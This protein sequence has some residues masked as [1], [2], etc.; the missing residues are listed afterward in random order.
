MRPELTITETKAIQS[1]ATATFAVPTIIHQK[2]TLESEPGIS[3]ACLKILPELPMDNAEQGQIILFDPEKSSY[4]LYNPSV[5]ELQNISDDR[6][7]DLIVSPNRMLYAYR[8]EQSNKLMVFSSGGELQRSINWENNWETLGKWQ[9]NEHILLIKSSAASTEEYPRHLIV[10][11]P[12]SG[13]TQDLQP[14]YP[15]IENASYQLSWEGSGTTVYDPMF[16][17]VVYPGVIEG[18]GMGYI[19]FDLKNKT[20]LA[21]IQS[22]NFTKAPKWL[23]DG[24]QFIV[25]AKGGEFFLVSRDGEITQISHMSPDYDPTKNNFNYEASFYSWSPDGK[26]LALW[27]FSYKTN[28]T[29]LAVLDI[30][31]GTVTDF[32]LSHGPNPLN[33]PY[34]PIPIWSPD[35]TAIVVEANFQSENGENDVMLVDLIKK[36]AT[37]I[38]QNLTPVGWLDVP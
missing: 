17:R 25:N 18:K 11:N 4:V 24:S 10:L 27:L 6:V 8:D 5:K 9:N 37:R 22:P 26:Y 14:I 2:D 19:L 16:T 35:S 29:T 30:H 7:F 38:S 32:C 3:Q 33:M 13:E 15:S 12:F 31:S 1:V 20:K 36:N 28:D 34:F 21:E 23:Y